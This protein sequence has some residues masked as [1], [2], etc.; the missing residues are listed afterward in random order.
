MTCSGDMVPMVSGGIRIKFHFLKKNR[1]S[2]R[3]VIIPGDN[4]KNL[5]AFFIPAFE[6][7]RS[8]FLVSNKKHELLIRWTG[9]SE[10]DRDLYK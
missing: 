5:H 2:V 1:M 10:D 4:S 6:K 7:H 9:F 3:I 8:V